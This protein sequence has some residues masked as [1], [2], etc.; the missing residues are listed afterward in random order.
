MTHKIPKEE[1]HFVII[2]TL[3]AIIMVTGVS[4]GTTYWG[5][6]LL[7][8][9]PWWWLATPIVLGLDFIAFN[10]TYYI[11]EVVAQVTNP[12]YEIQDWPDLLRK[13]K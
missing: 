5:F 2:I 13:K 1:F 6:W 10:N 7:P 3:M 12:G 9:N 8:E 4:F 11:L